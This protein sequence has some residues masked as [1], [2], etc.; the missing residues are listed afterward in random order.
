M[1]ISGINKAYQFV[2]SQHA[3]NQNNQSTGPSIATQASLAAAA[4]P[5]AIVTISAGYNGGNQSG[6]G[7]GGG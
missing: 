4:N 1:R 5:S 3:S 2:Q 6:G 7:S